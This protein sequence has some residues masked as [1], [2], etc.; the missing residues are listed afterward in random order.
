MSYAA[1]GGPVA[2]QRLACMEDVLRKEGSRSAAAAADCIPLAAD[3]YLRE[4][5]LFQL[6]RE[7][8]VFAA[9]PLGQCALLLGQGQRGESCKTG[10]DR[11]N[12]LQKG[13]SCFVL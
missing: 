2:L 8:V 9:G 13:K 5:D 4:Q 6:R 7:D 11:K 3:G 1:E 12:A 10:R